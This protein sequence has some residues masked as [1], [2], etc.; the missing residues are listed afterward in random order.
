[1][2]ALDAM[3]TAQSAP[4]DAAAELRSGA[5]RRCIVTRD[6][7]PKDLLIRFVIGP[8]GEIVPDVQGR[9][10]GRGLWVK[11]ERA[12]LASAVARN[13]FAKAARAAVKIPSDLVDRTASLLRQ[14]CLD[15]LG[16]ARRAGQ[17]V[18]GFEKVSDALRTARVA[19]L[20][21]ANDAAPDGRSKLKAMAG[22]LPTLS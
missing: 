16:L 1:M 12:A 4:D 9:L 15:Q 13:L 2:D 22:G 21:A 10:P 20:V 7:L 11:A 5:L 3:A 6:V 18:C 17:V 19:V 8:S 14:R